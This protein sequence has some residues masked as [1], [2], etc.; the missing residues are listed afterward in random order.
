MFR[1]YDHLQEE[2]YA[3][4]MLYAWLAFIIFKLVVCILLRVLCQVQGFRLTQHWFE[5]L[6]SNRYMLR[7]YDHLRAEMYTCCMLYAWLAFIILK[8]V[9]C[10][11]LRVLGQVQGFRLTQ[12]WFEYL[13]SNRYMFRSYDHLHVMY[14]L[15]PEDGH[16]TETRSVYW[17]NIQTSVALDGNPEPDL[18]RCMLTFSWFIL[19]LSCLTVPATEDSLRPLNTFHPY[20]LHRPPLWS[21]GQSSWLRAMRSVKVATLKGG[22]LA[23]KINFRANN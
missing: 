1:S 22:K 12:H 17:I 8:L 2:M 5:Y 11:L 4:C 23:P 13:F 19:V 14:T 9:V 3:C 21:S 16:K 10:I 15:P 18:C 7:S 20:M 6:F